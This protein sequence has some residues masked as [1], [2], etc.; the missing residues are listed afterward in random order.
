[1]A[2]GEC[3]GSY[4]EGVII[5][6]SALSAI[7]A[8]VWP[9]NKIDKKRF[10][11]AVAVYCDVELKPKRISVPLLIEYLDNNGK[12]QEAA[13]LRTQFMSFP[14]GQLLTG[15]Q[16]DR[17]EDEICRACPG[18]LHEQIRR[19]A[20]AAVFYD[21]VR[22]SYV[23]KY[24]I[25]L[26]ADPWAVAATEDTEISYGNWRADPIRHIHFPIQWISKVAESVAENVD[27]SAQ[28]LPLVQP[29]RWWLEG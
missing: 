12:G 4:A 25:G 15:S 10:V 1:M 19:F 2:E 9:G 22:S 3:D 27:C 20:Y 26:S 13:T 5:L 28:E 18:L 21:E 16:V 11:E 7:A 6:S 14:R 17:F 8:E 23:H 24:K 29:G